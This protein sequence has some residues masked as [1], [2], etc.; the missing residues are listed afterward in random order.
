M[1][2][3]YRMMLCGLAIGLALSASAYGQRMTPELKAL[4]ARL[5][6]DDAP[7]RAAAAVALGDMGKDAAP[8]V[9][10][11]IKVLRDMREVFVVARS[12]ADLA[13]RRRVTI[14]PGGVGCRSSVSEQASI[15]LGKIGDRRAVKP[16]CALM[17]DKKR[18]DRQ[19]LK[20]VAATKA[21]G[22]IGNAQAVGS[23]LQAFANPEEY[24]FIHDEAGDALVKIGAPAVKLL[25]RVAEQGNA[26][27]RLEAISA[28]AKIGRP[29]VSSLVAMLNRGD[30]KTTKFIAVALGNTQ[31]LEALEALITAL[32]SKKA[33]VRGSAM[34]GLDR[35][36]SMRN[37]FVQKRDADDVLAAKIRASV[38]SLQDEAV[39]TVIAVF[40]DP[41][42]SIDVRS[43]AA[44][45]LGFS[46]DP[47]VVEPLLKALGDRNDK[48]RCAVLS[49]ICDLARTASAKSDW[50][51]EV[52]EAEREKWDE[53]KENLLLVLREKA[54]EPLI[55]YLGDSDSHEKSTARYALKYLTG[56][57]FRD[58]KEWQAWWKKHSTESVS[59]P[60][61]GR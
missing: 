24:Y 42:Q 61:S 34:A 46:R 60:R 17:L 40:E 57:N 48:V 2:T 1:R 39:E 9:P 29:A 16:L 28:L 23:L 52:D 20:R 50:F 35:F 44:S 10:W 6:S 38:R 47:R 56:Q 4:L 54:T 27:V 25:V 3:C 19:W 30:P 33:S 49:A 41:R 12:R 11:L 5:V 22:E 36:C 21:L 26:R 55:G 13:D 59:A 37:V 32:K 51:P 8:A 45:V 7:T 14:G 58:Y 53:N 15:A 31:E 43:N 18:D